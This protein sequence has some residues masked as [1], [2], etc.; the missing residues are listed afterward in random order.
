MSLVQHN[1]ENT[2]PT[3]DTDCNSLSIS[4]VGSKNM[5]NTNPSKDANS[6][7]LDIS[8]VDRKNKE[9]V[10]MDFNFNQPANLGFDLN[11]Y[12]EEGNEAFEDKERQEVFMSILKVLLPEFY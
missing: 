3:I 1:M 11:K 6:N 4:T 10:V 7:S 2:N 5:E 8:T 9:K 12:P